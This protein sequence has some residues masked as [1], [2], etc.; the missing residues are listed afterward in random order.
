MIFTLVTTRKEYLE[1]FYDCTKAMSMEVFDCPTLLDSNHT[2][3]IIIKETLKNY[4]A[5]IYKSSLNIT[6]FYIYV[7]QYQK[8]TLTCKYMKY[9]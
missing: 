4:T 6:N 9:I 7:C 1:P 2:M 8:V 5:E 3:Y